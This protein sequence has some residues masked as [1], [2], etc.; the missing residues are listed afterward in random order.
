MPEQSQHVSYKRPAIEF[1]SNTFTV[2]VLIL[3]TNDLNIIAEQLKIKIKQAPEFF[4]NSPLLF[5]LQ[6]IVKQQLVLDLVLLHKTVCDLQFIPV[7]IRGGNV[8]HN[9]VAHSI[10]LAVFSN[11]RSNSGQTGK[12]TKKIAPT[13]EQKPDS[14]STETRVLTHPVRSGQRIYVKGDL[15]ILAAVSSGAELMAEGNIHIYGALRGRALAGVQG[16]TASRIFCSDL[17]AELISIAGHYKVNDDLNQN[18]RGKPVQIYLQ[19]KALIIKD[20]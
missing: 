15:V 16:N 11:H 9:K 6:E 10:N 19:D 2:P 18:V 20:I 13:N 5:D 8:E 3:G 14:E 12:Q 7:G 1:K 17:Q 4:K